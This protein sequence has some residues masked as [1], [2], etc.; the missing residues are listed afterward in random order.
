MRSRAHPYAAHLVV[1]RKSLETT[2]PQTD[3]GS[4]GTRRVILG[5]GGA[6]LVLPTDLAADAKAAR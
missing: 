5:W 1:L 6:P 3:F 4:P 2:V